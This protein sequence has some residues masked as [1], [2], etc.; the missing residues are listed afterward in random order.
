[1]MYLIVTEKPSVG[2]AIAD[3]LGARE[4]HEGYLQGRNCIVS[5]CIGHL[6]EL[7]LP[8]SYDPAFARWKYD[9]LPILPEEWQFTVSEDTKAQFEILKKLMHDERMTEV[10]C[11]TDAGREG[12]LIFR[13]VYDKAGCK[14]PVRR[15]WISSMEE[16]AIREGFRNLKDGK[17]F[18]NLYQAALCRAKADWMVGMN[19]T[20]LYSLLY[21][22]TLH[23]G[24][25][26]TPTMA[27]IAGR[28]ADIRAFQSEPFFMVKLRVPGL[29]A[30]SERF[31]TR[32]EA[33]QL[34]ERCDRDSVV[35]TKIDKRSHAERAPLLYDL[36][37]LQRDANRYLGFTAQ[38]TLEYAQNL[39]EKRLLTYPR[40]DSRFL[41]HDMKETL[42]EL[43][44]QIGKALPF[45]NGFSFAVHADTV[46]NDAKVTD[47]HAI[48][49]TR[50]LP[51]MNAVVAS[52]STGERDLLYLVC[53]RL[54]C[55]V[56][57]PCLYDETVVTLRCGSHD[58][59]AKGKQVRQIGWRAIWY[60]FRGSLLSR[61]AEA[62]TESTAIPDGIT[63]GLEMPFPGTEVCEGKTTP[64]ARYSENT[65]L[66]DMETAG[67]K[68]MPE[69]AERKGIGT[70]ATRAAILEKL[71]ETGLI[72]RKGDR[73]QKVLVPTQMGMA[74][75]SV[76][77]E[78]LLSPKLTADWENRL[79][80]IEHGEESP[81]QFLRDIEGML[82]KLVK[83]VHRAEQAEE[84]F[85]P[86]REK[87][88]TCPHCGAAVTEREPGFMCENRTCGFALW[89]N[90]GFLKNASKKLTAGDVR[91]LLTNGFVHMDGLRSPKTRKAYSATVFLEYGENGK[92]V[93]R[94]SFD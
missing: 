84:L 23:V 62:E 35:V 92:P 64:P 34:K 53:T 51:D 11:A 82:E 32:E 81:E 26:M 24:R 85:P 18:D 42:P 21:G 2:R 58:F 31:K 39:Y 6:V 43:V 72:E 55:A 14:L 13:L 5:W 52:L 16:S 73:K 57:D 46:I 59:S 54:L 78:D 17:D 7:A 37:T 33:Q 8:A 44:N 9:D 28:E 41:T 22:P 88:G 50:S 47:H 66:H 3:A 87:I 25:V 40:T 93:L 91:E 94:P 75:A 60:T 1:M 36:T 20:R 48:I 65:I 90:H 45:A 76:L 69:D 86:L 49:P 4:R 15:L 77:P 10:I 12:E 30:Q 56:S 74:L 79:K 38:Q 61:I 71:I 67:V 83:N 70:P 27:M 68:D 19:A 63:E 29:E 89:K 80:R